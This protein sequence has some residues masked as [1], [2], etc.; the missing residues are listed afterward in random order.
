MSYEKLGSEM[1][2]SGHIFS[3]EK[4]K[5]NL[6]DGRARSYDCINIQNAVTILPVDKQGNIY[7]V[8]Q[9]RIGAEQQ[10]LELPAGKIEDGEEALKTAER[11]IREETG[12]AAGKIESLGKFYVSPGYSTEFMYSFLA[13][14]LYE[15]PLDPDA[16][17]FLNLVKIPLAEVKRMVQAGELQDGKTLATLL[18]A[19]PRLNELQ[20][21]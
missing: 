1:I 14:E 11:E 16:D 7:F 17:E 15:A 21:K 5:L 9:Y 19:L 4:V 10:L 8:R 20:A 3:V 13:T 12:M 2:Y 6:P 18:L